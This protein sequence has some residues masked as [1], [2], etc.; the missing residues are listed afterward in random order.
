M[1][2]RLRQQIRSD[3]LKAL[4][5]PTLLTLS[6]LVIVTP[7][8]I[9]FMMGLIDGLGSVTSAEATRI[10]LPI[11]V[12]GSLGCAFYGSYLV[13]RDDYY[14]GMER[15]FLMASPRV[16][17]A[18]RIVVAA[19]IGVVFSAAGF[20]LWTGVMAAVLGF[21]DRELTI[22]SDIFRFVIGSLLAGAFSAA[23]GCSVGWV[24]RNYYVAVVVLLI[25]PSVIAVPMLG[26]LRDIERFLPVGAIAG[27]GG[28]RM[29]GL[30]GQAP[31][32]L[33]LTGWAMLDILAGWFS[34]RRRIQV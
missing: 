32:G 29:D 19:L 31:A 34:L 28:V 33:I 23:I 21:H 3:L 5:G 27:L 15:G 4:S 10:L 6:S 2:A 8:L 1:S 17:F 7:L 20:L 12:A 13:T 18:S 30:L 24:V 9:V 26:R 22:G 11:G 16:V 14:R 25:L